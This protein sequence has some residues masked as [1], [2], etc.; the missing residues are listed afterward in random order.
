MPRPP[1]EGATAT[2]S[3]GQSENGSELIAE[4]EGSKAAAG[5][6]RGIHG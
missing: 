6:Q 1:S 3:G 4:M 2:P 5:E